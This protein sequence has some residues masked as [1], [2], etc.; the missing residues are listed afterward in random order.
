M[1]V[2]SLFKLQTRVFALTTAKII[3]DHNSLVPLVNWLQPSSTKFY[4]FEEL[5]FSFS[6]SQQHYALLPVLLFSLTCNSTYN[7]WQCLSATRCP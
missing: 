3:C 6:Y 7:E 2:S 1:K 5:L 4:T